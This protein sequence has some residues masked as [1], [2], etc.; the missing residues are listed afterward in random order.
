MILEF[1]VSNAIPILD[2]ER[3]IISKF[4]FTTKNTVRW[5]P[6]DQTYSTSYQQHS[7]GFSV[8]SVLSEWTKR[9]VLITITVSS[10]KNIS[11]SGS[12]YLQY[13]RSEAEQKFHRG[14]AKLTSVPPAFSFIQQNLLPPLV[15]KP[16]FESIHSLAK[17]FLLVFIY[18]D[19]LIKPTQTA[20]EFTVYFEN[21][22]EE[23]MTSS[24][25]RHSQPVELE[26]AQSRWLI[27][28]TP[29][30]ALWGYSPTI[31]IET[32]A[33]ARV[34][35]VLLLLLQHLQ[36]MGAHSALSSTI[37]WNSLMPTLANLTIKTTVMLCV[38]QFNQQYTTSA[39]TFR[40]IFAWDSSP[41]PRGIK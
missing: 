27:S 32:A 39:L 9:T 18:I 31:S 37:N 16:I 7:L 11:C 10:W 14:T 12:L 28:V 17:A 13:L 6:H 29:V 19:H 34:W 5:Q 36:T 20:C 1:H 38:L 30:R 41:Q 33:V 26:S 35:T 40:I 21:V 3:G 23:A 24:T 2:T 4:A 8:R 15:Y 22:L 25:G